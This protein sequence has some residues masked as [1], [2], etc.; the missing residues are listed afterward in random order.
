MYEVVEAKLESRHDLGIEIDE[1]SSGSD[2]SDDGNDFSHVGN[3]DA[4]TGVDG[5]DQDILG[6]GECTN[7]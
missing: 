3:T 5:Q 2:R 4:F 7:R 6:K 1:E